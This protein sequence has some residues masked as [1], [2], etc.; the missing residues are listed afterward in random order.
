M[1][2]ACGKVAAGW[3]NNS[4]AVRTP[5]IVEISHRRLERPIANSNGA[6]DKGAAAEG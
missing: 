3:F 6:M 4:I 5:A 1:A 2:M